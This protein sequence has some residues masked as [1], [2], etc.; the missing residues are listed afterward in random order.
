MAD[1]DIQYL[2]T[3]ER[4]G[5]QMMKVKVID[6][7]NF[8]HYHMNTFKG[9]KSLKELEVVMDER[10]GLQQRNFRDQN[11]AIALIWQFEDERREDPAWECPRVR[12]VGSD[13]GKLY[14]ESQGGALIPGW[15]I[16]DEVPDGA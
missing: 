4:D 5:I 16:G 13:T 9:L 6:C 15:K 2:G 11:P 8:G 3:E 10:V 7:S 12:I 1:K 14:G